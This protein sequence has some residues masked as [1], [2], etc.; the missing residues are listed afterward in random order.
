MT[1]AEK[2]KVQIYKRSLSALEKVDKVMDTLDKVSDKFSTE[3]PDWIVTRNA[4]GYL[5]DAKSC[6]EILRNRNYI[7]LPPA[8]KPEDNQPKLF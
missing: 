8:I 1:S 4:L 2:R 5:N 3:S 7:K 6:I